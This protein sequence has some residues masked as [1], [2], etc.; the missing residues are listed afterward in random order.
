MLLVSITISFFGYLHSVLHVIKQGARMRVVITAKRLIDRFMNLIKEGKCY[1]ITNYQCTYWGDE[2]H[3]KHQLRFGPKTDMEE[4]HLPLP[5]IS[6]HFMTISE[7]YL[8]AH[9]TSSY[10][11]TDVYGIVVQVS[12]MNYVWI[13]GDLIEEL[14]IMIQ[15]AQ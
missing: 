9:L 12:P 8:R 13:E 3:Q 5:R 6:F 7:T 15:S 14:P 4:C 10:F 11:H 2:I 1:I